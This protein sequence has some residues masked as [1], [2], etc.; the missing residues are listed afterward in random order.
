MKEDELDRIEREAIEAIERIRLEFE[1]AAA[2]YAK[3]VAD[4]RALRPRVWRDDEGRL[5]V[6]FLP[7]DSANA[8]P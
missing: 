1:R 6:P 8:S 3:I 2:P 7:P 5:M 4:V